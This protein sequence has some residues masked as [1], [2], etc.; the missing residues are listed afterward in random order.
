MKKHTFERPHIL[1]EYQLKKF[2]C[3][4]DP[5]DEDLYGR[6]LWNL[7]DNA[8][9]KFRCLNCGREWNWL[10]PKPAQKSVSIELF[11]YFCLDCGKREGIDGPNQVCKEC[12][13]RSLNVCLDSVASIN[14]HISELKKELE[15]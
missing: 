10:P 13:T 11:S 1:Y 9:R 7:M 12:K 6:P 14:R 3:L 8:T 15:D 2:V 4:C 5:K